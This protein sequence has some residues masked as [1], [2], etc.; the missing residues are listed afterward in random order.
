MSASLRERLGMMTGTDLLPPPRPSPPANGSRMTDQLRR[1]GWTQL[2]PDVHGRDCEIPVPEDLTGP[3][4]GRLLPAECRLKDCLF[5]DTETTG[6]AGAGTVIFLMGCAWV[7]GPRLRIRQVFLADFPGE[8]RFLEHLRE[9][10]S[11]FQVFVSYNGKAFDSTI[12]KTRLVMSGMTM[13]LGY[14]LDLLYLA[15]RFWRRLLAN[16][17]LTT[18]EQEVLGERRVDDVPGWMV[19]D[20]YFDSLRRGALGRLPAVFRHNELDVIALARLLGVVSDILA[21]NAQRTPAAGVDRAAVGWFLLQQ[22]D[23]RG[24]RM[25]RLAYQAGDQYAG[26]LLGGHLKRAG[27]WRDAVIVWQ[28]L[29]RTHDSLDAAVELSKYYEHRARD[30]E[31]ALTWIVPFVARDVAGEDL[32]H[33]EARIRNK[34]RRSNADQEPGGLRQVPGQGPAGPEAAPQAAVPG[35]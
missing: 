17:R 23:R 1:A 7:E 20:I 28:D 15:R 34:L 30:L 29:V 21:G 32:L 31:A 26:H 33:R 19:P 4:A 6:L 8:Q 2:A 9:L 12:L 22:G 35:R 10:F 3:V 18:I 25:L 14:Q 5:W 13:A 11:R 27:E 16:C 24:A